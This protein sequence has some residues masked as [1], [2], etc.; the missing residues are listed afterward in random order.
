M[1]ECNGM[2]TTTRWF[3]PPPLSRHRPVHLLTMS[4]TTDAATEQTLNN[5]R[6]I[7]AEMVEVAA[8]LGAAAQLPATGL[9]LMVQLMRGTT[10]DGQTPIHVAFLP[11]YLTADGVVLDSAVHPKVPGVLYSTLMRRGLELITKVGTELSTNPNVV[12]PFRA[13]IHVDSLAA[14]TFNSDL[15][16]NPPFV[17][18]QRAIFETYM[19]DYAKVH[20]LEVIR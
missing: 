11:A 5:V 17:E 12:Y 3:K 7:F 19:N 18:D 8:G 14:G 2:I 16:L 10:V 4:D 15:A 1:N 13:T 20:D 9:V 6:S